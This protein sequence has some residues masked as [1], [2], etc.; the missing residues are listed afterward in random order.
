MEME[1]IFR[2]S[3]PPY[4]LGG[5]LTLS[6]LSLGVRMADINLISNHTK[7]LFPALGGS[8]LGW[9]VQK[10]FNRNPTIFAY[11]Y[12]E[13]EEK[14]LL[15]LAEIHKNQSLFERTKNDDDN[16]ISYIPTIYNI[17]RDHGLDLRRVNYTPSTLI[18]TL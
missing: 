4:E 13:N 8:G 18:W 15:N 5:L 2:D 16:S 9:R 12:G 3:P 14:R 1:Q 17:I 7:T 11:I 10:A 6:Y